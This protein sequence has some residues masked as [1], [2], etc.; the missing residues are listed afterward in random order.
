M[1]ERKARLEAR[2][3]QDLDR[4]IAEAAEVLHVSKSAFVSDA[5]REAAM[6]VV[7]RAETTLMSAEVFDEMMASIDVADQS[8]E[9]AD[10]AAMPRRI[11]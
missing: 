6:K 10:L 8:R 9:L 7:A 4:L 3:D 11:S 5:L 1:V 2:I